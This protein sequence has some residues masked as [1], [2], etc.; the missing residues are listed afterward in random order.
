MLYCKA[1]RKI[2]KE[3]KIT[4]TELA[5]GLRKTRETISSWES[6]R[7]R[8]CDSDIRLMAQILNVSVSAISDLSEIKIKPEETHD[9]STLDTKD[10][11]SDAAKRLK[12]MYD[13]YLDMGAANARLR[14]NLLKYETF[15]QSI[16]LMI[17]VKDKR[18]KYTYA[19]DNFLNLIG[20]AHSGTS[21]SG[22]SSL[23]I[24][25]FK[26]YSQLLDLEQQVL[27]TKQSIFREQIYVPG[28][29]KNK[30]G[31]LTITPVLNNSKEVEELVVSIEN[32]QDVSIT[33]NSFKA[34]SSLAF[35]S[36]N[37]TKSYNNVKIGIV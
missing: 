2:R 14:S 7:Y 26:E 27:R 13:S 24:F 33:N 9:Y 12:N 36:P 16:P 4:E 19:N 11:P 10:L 15:L 21:I 30:I 31:V 8:P 22:V 23:D 35:E 20:K 34:I 32:I 29:F 5:K 25:E 18:L 17:Y 28:T 37:N 6:G 1:L 3:K